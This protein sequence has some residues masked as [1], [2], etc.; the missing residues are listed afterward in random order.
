MLETM[1]LRKYQANRDVKSGWS[2]VWAEPAVP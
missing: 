1:A 2:V